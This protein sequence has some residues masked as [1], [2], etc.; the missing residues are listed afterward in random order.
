MIDLNN[1]TIE[2]K[3]IET[4][5]SLRVLPSGHVAHKLTEFARGGWRAPT[6]EQTKLFHTRSGD[7]RPVTLPGELRPRRQQQVADLSSG[8]AYTTSDP[9]HPFFMSS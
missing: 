4:T 3:R 1:D 8:S 7:F 5:T 6:S 2:L 9:S